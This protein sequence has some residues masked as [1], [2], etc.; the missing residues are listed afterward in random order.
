[1]PYSKKEKRNAIKEMDQIIKK[2]NLKVGYVKVT[3]T[4]PEHTLK[5][6]KKLGK[7]KSKIIERLIENQ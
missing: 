3:F 5:K 1:M 2:E 6:L 7:S 4:L